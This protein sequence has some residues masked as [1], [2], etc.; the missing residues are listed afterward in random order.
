MSDSFYEDLFSVRDKVA[1]VTGG[2]R[3]IGLMIAEG[4]VRAG[5][6]VYVA[7]RKAEACEEAQAKLGK[8]GDCTAIV[9]D[10]STIEGC[11]HLAEEIGN[12]ED[13]LHILV[14]NAGVTWS[15]SI[16]DF[17]EKAWD[18]VMD[19]DVKG[20]FFLIQKLLP[21]LRK[22]AGAESRSS[23]VN[24]TSVNGLRP[25]GLQNY[26]YV[27]AKAGLGQ[28]SLQMARDLMKDY[29]NVNVVAPGLFKS[30]MTASLF[31]SEETARKVVE[32]VPMGR[33]GAMEDIAG[34]VIFFSSKAGSF[35]TGT[36][37]SCDG[38]SVSCGDGSVTAK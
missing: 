16:D 9:S 14:N 17:T 26:S 5:A 25:S 37:V 18:K 12:R 4:L 23:I 24:I 21:L 11:T 15:L 1:L 33:A 20:P 35:L 29:I 19:L 31:A 36:T 2:T 28:L 7:S 13:K 6:R 10:V 32:S 38:G 3:G 34:L 27:A 22:A 30:K 8:L